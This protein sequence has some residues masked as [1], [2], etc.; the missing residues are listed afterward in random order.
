MPKIKISPI[1]LLIIPLVI[2]DPGGQIAT[3]VM[4]A[5]IHEIGHL[6]T[7]VLCGVGFS[8]LNITPYGLEITTSRPYRNF[9]EEIAVNASG[10]AV[11]FLCYFLFRDVNSLIGFANASLVLGTLNALPVLSLDG[12]EVVFSALSVFLPYR[13]ACRISRLISFVTLLC[14]W[15]LAAYIFLFSGYNYS[16]FIMT[17]W[18]FGKIYCH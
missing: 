12:G 15:T 18:L 1:S 6:L 7:I 8:C 16:L 9:Y 2:S 3:T 13:S 4:S 14:M 5:A 17:V 10:C 11:N